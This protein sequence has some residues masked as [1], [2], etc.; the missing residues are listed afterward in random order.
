LNKERKEFG[1]DK[2]IQVMTLIFSF[3]KQ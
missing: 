1:A 3:Y 2:K